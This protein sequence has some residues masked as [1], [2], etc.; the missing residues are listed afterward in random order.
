MQINRIEINSESLA[1]LYLRVNSFFIL[2]NF[3]IHTEIADASDTRTEIDVCGVRFPNTSIFINED[4]KDDTP[5]NDLKKPIC[6]IGEVK[7]NKKCQVNRSIKNQ[8]TLCRA[9]QVIGVFSNDENIKAANYL[10]ETGKYE[11]DNFTFFLTGIGTQESKS[12]ENSYRDGLQ[13]TW[14]NIL[15]FL[16][17]RFKQVQRQK[18]NNVQWE[19]IGKDFFRL[20]IQS[21]NFDTFREMISI[22]D[23]KEDVLPYKVVV[24]KEIEKSFDYL[25]M[26]HKLSAL[27]NRPKTEESLRNYLFNTHFYRRKEDANNFIE[28][29]KREKIISIR[30]QKIDWLI[31]LDDSAHNEA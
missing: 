19:S 12:F 21:P 10:L 24:N 9:L 31:E 30:N 7:T 1:K 29:I 4:I 18:R 17:E 2:S 22:V 26:L 5:F 3:I 8:D 28:Y 27:E 14:D 6:L 23:T 15:R 20:A 11:T 25:H 13:I 16:F